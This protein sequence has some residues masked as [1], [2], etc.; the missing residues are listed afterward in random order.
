MITDE[1]QVNYC[2][3]MMIKLRKLDDLENIVSSLS[4]ITMLLMS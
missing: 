4:L 3:Q 2:F 1:Q